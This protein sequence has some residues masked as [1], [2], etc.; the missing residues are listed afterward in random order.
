MSTSSA[1][2]PTHAYACYLCSA[3]WGRELE[4]WVPDGDEDLGLGLEMDGGSGGWDQF[5]V[6]QHASTHTVHRD[7][8]LLD[9]TTVP[10]QA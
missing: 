2:T 5:A 6:S 4:A 10:V 7:A 3:T 1:P 9:C 8:L